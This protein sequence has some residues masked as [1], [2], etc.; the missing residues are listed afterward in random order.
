MIDSHGSVESKEFENNREY[1]VREANYSMNVRDFGLIGKMS[2][3]GNI[4][5][6]SE[7]NSEKNEINNINN[8]FQ[9]KDLRTQLEKR[10][11][12]QIRNNNGMNEG[13][14]PIQNEIEKIEQI[15]KIQESKIKDNVTKEEVKKLVKLYLKSYDS[16]KDNEGR[17]IN[18]T[19]I[20]SQLYFR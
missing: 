13:T 5:G 1:P 17:L 11:S 14:K 16:N 7:S 10:K 2:P 4:E 15:A 3:G 18:N 12:I 8:N 19:E 20:Y 9:I 6:D